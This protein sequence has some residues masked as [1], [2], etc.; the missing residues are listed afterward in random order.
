MELAPICI[1]TY[2][3]LNTTKLTID[4]LKKNHLAKESCVYIFS[5]GPKS[6]EDTA[7]IEQVRTYLDTVDGFKEI[8]IIKK[9]KN[10]GLSKSIIT[11][12]SEIMNQFG[13]AIV[14]EDDIYTSP[15]FL[16]FINQGLDKY[17]DNPHIFNISGYTFPIKYPPQYDYDVY[18]AQRA[19]CWGWGSWKDRWSNIDW[20][21]KDY[22]SFRKDS[23]LKHQIKQ[24]G[25]DMYR[26]VR[27][28][29][30][31]K[32]DSWD[33]VWTYNQFRFKQYAI[34]PTVSKV[35][36][37]GFG[38]DATHTKFYNRFQ[39]T[40]D[41]SNQTAFNMPDEMVLDKTIVRAFRDKNSLY[42]RALGR[43][44]YYLGFT[45]KSSI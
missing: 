38:D 14:V 44:K 17:Q 5:D 15:N 33:T 24:G 40:L 23:Q 21:I 27:R 42:E 16:D 19:S 7:Q 41:N 32:I 35:Q 36:N 43:L 20:E 39:T 8:K 10:S 26:L 1:F 12:V 45:N 3:R 31:G 6:Q 18:F 4:A 2:K 37:I 11:G 22:E 13:K 9:E 34:F 25:S 28:Q 30:E 29:M